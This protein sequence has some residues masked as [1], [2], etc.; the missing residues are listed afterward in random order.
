MGVQEPAKT[1]TRGDLCNLWKVTAT[2]GGSCYLEKG[3]CPAHLQQGQQGGG[4]ADQQARIPVNFAS[5]GTTSKYMKK[6]ITE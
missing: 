2:E 5:L 6:K 1:T 3:K 4:S